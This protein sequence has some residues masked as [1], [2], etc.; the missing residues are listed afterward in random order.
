M[1][2]RRDELDRVLA[3][4]DA[5]LDAG[6]SPV[7]MNVVVIRG[8]N[9]HEVVDIAGFGRDRGVGVRFI[10]FMPLDAPGE[11]TMDQVVPS[12]EILERIHAVY[13]LELGTGPAPAA[14]VEPAARVR[15]RDGQGDVGV[16]ASV[17]EPFCE[18]CDRVRVTADGRFR[19]C[20]FALEETDLRAVLRGGGTDDDLAGAI[21]GAVATK[22]ARAPDRA[23]QL[24]PP[25]TIDEPDRWIAPASR[26]P[27]WLRSS[28]IS[29]RSAA[30]GWWTSRPRIRATGGPWPAAGCYMEPDTASRIASG[31]IT[32][33]DVLAVARVAGIQAAKQTANLLP[34]CHPLLVGS[35]FVNFRIE[36]RHVEV[37]SQV[38]TFDRTGVEMEALTA[39]TIAALTVYDMCKSLDR[40]MTIGDVALWEKTGGRSGVWRRPGRDGDD[41]G[42]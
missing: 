40:G 38:D 7:K 20:L 27:G 37:E 1:L 30:P 21:E 26:M 24:R 41:F 39:C 4:I 16:I 15:Y 11:W 6:L 17:T 23:G 9:D 5:A 13:P 34:L 29:T 2:T 3:G 36:D 33:G 22:W 10:E 18:R 12:Q 14:H 35:V 25:V 31:A 28:R 32:K 19:T 8:V 42:L